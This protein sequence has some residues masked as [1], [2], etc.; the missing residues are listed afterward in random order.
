MET[1]EGNVSKE[2]ERRLQ[3]E[4][5]EIWLHIWLHACTHMHSRELIQEKL[6]KF[7]GISYTS[8]YCDK[9]SEKLL[10]EEEVYLVSGSE[11]LVSYGRVG[12]AK[13]RALVCG[14]RSIS[15]IA[16]ICLNKER[17]VNAFCLVLFFPY[18]FCLG[19]EPMR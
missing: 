17:K 16:Y 18:L 14:D 10:M 13:G 12:I 4:T 15:L 2:K 3:N 11:G 5:Q 1:R 9:S 8:C 19:T 7:K 6:K